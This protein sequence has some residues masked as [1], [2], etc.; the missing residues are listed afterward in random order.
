MKLFL[1]YKYQVFR[2]LLFIAYV[3]TIIQ[4]KY[5][6]LNIEITIVNQWFLDFFKD[7]IYWSFLERVNIT[8][9]TTKI[10]F[11]LLII[12]PIILCCL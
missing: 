3:F 5:D 6:F 8:T 7:S 2:V 12:L 9:L 11:T 1:L 4:V 10:L